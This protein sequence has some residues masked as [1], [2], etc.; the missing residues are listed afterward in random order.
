MNAV[1]TLPVPVTVAT[2]TATNAGTDP[3]PGFVEL[4]GEFVTSAPTAESGNDAPSDEATE[5]VDATPVDAPVEMMPATPTWLPDP[6]PVA[7]DVSTVGSVDP[8]AVLGPVP[9]TDTHTTSGAPATWTPP[10]AAPTPDPTGS[11]MSGPTTST[12]PGR[13]P[14]SDR[15]RPIADPTDSTAIDSPPAPALPDPPASE[16]TRP[17][18]P[19]THPPATTSATGPIAVIGPDRR[20]A[21]RPNDGSVPAGIAPSSSASTVTTR[22]LPATDTA[23]AA[24]PPPG[25]RVHEL[26]DLI[27]GTFLR[28][29][30]ARVRVQ[31]HPEHLGAV[32]VDVRRVAG[33]L[34]VTVTANT[35]EA[36]AQLRGQHQELLHRLDQTTTAT[37]SLHFDLS[38]ASGDGTSDRRWPLDG[39]NAADRRSEPRPTSDQAP[40]PRRS[41]LLIG[42]TGRLLL[43][44]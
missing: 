23:P 31:L 15:G 10:D 41:M 24:A 4:L 36:L 30:P 18:A 7:P 1:P 35:N 21:E 9:A 16:L 2:G 6:T 26:A 25:I 42:S 28:A 34:Q 32:T 8:D 13:E 5:D 40:A 11:E 17:P 39:P 14:A 33:Q 37:V 29:T 3:E 38:S 27:G 12:H 22:L 44:L 43:D 19:A 20:S